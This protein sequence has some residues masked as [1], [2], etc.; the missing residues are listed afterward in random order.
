MKLNIVTRSLHVVFHVLFYVLYDVYVSVLLLFFSLFSPLAAAPGRVHPRFGVRVW[1][2]PLG[3]P[4]WRGFSGPRRFGSVHKAWSRCSAAHL[5]SSSQRALRVRAGLLPP[6][7][8]LSS[9]NTVGRITP[10]SQQSVNQYLKQSPSKTF[11]KR[12]S[13]VNISKWM[14]MSTTNLRMY[15]RSVRVCLHINVHAES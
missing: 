6:S 12:V 9:S 13:G 15:S 3:Y 8:F 11:G 1:L 7:L 5:S 2:R 14:S 4:T 10:S